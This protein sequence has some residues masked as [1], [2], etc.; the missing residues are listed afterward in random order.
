[1][2]PHGIRVRH[3]RTKSRGAALVEAV[4]VLP[5]VALLVFGVIELGM[6]FRTATVATNASRAGAREMASSFANVADGPLRTGVVN[7]AALVV[8]EALRDRSSTDTPQRLLIYEARADGTPVD[9]T[10]PCNVQCF[11]FTWNAPGTR[12]NAPSGAWADAEVDA[13]GTPMD[14]VGVSIRLTHGG[15]IGPWRFTRPIDEHSVMYL[16]PSILC[17]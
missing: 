13:C 4:F 9:Q 10:G 15:S 7:R 11:T 2:V 16:E 17:A 6:V 12:W 1:M 5:F 8:E 3:N 14:L